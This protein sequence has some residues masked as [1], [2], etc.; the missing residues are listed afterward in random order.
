VERGQS[1]ALLSGAQCQDKRQWAQPETQ[2][3]PSEHQKTVLNCEGQGALAQVA[4][5]GCG[6]SVVGDTQ[7]LPRHSPGQ[8]AL[9]LPVCTGGLDQMTSRSP[10][11]PQL[12]W[13]FVNYVEGEH[14]PTTVFNPAFACNTQMTIILTLKCPLQT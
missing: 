11:Q 1:Q 14:R 7:K 8:L 10:F 12:F 3:V 2:E 6:V 5:G 4:Q 13:D 9:G